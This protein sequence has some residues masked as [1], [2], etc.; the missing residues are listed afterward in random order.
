[1]DRYR[2]PRDV[3]NYEVQVEGPKQFDAVR[4]EATANR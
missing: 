2:D 4:A 1:V 3:G